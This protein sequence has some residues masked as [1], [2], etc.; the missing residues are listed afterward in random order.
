[1]PSRLRSSRER[2]GGGTSLPRKERLMETKETTE[3]TERFTIS[4]EKS[5]TWLLRKFRQISEERDA[6]K[7]ATAQRLSELE[8]DED[9]LTH[10][11]GEQLKAWATTESEKRRRQTIT[12]PLAG[13]QV[14]FRKTSAAL[15]VADQAKAQAEATARGLVKTAPDL[16][17]YRMA[18]QSALEQSGEILPGVELK[19]ESQ[20]FTWRAIK[21]GKGA[22][23]AEEGGVE[24]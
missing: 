2:V 19:P 23:E 22:G 18:A 15:F 1:M 24:P 8:A 6:I 9:R 10:L 21:P 13:M 14:A 16:S 17:A 5:A 7:A 20:S 11:Y 4:D 3:A 12:L